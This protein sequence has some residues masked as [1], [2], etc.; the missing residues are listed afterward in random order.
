MKNIMLGRNFKS[1]ELE[2]FYEDKVLNPF[3]HAVR[4]KIINHNYSNSF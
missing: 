2:R 1:S 4:I 3:P